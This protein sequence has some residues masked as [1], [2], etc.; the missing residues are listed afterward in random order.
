M[1]GQ[2]LLV[3]CNG[4]DFFLQNLLP[5]GQ[6]SFVVNKGSND[7]DAIKKSKSSTTTIPHGVDFVRVKRDKG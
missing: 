1:H 6:V 5:N 7:T 2:F 4:L 3:S